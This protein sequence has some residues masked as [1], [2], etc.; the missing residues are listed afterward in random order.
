MISEEIKQQFYRTVIDKNVLIGDL[1]TTVFKSSLLETPL[2]LMIVISD[3]HVLYL[4]EFVDCRGL[5]REIKNLSLLY[6]ANIIAAHSAPIDVIKQELAAYFNGTLKEFTTKLHMTGTPFQKK[7]WNALLHIPYGQTRSYAAQA[8]VVGNKSACRAVGTANGCNQIA[9]VIPC[10]RIITSD[11][12]IGGYAG[13]VTRKQ[14][15]LDFERQH[16]GK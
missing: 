15:L 9:I 16:N 14:W 3:E 4:L 10:H 5:D 11:G 2:G 1:C 12:K 8:A 6:K 7:V 13:G